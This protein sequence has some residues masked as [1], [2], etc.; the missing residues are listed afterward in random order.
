MKS[1]IT[2]I[3]YYKLKYSCKYFSYKSRN[4]QRVNCLAKHIK[5]K[6]NSGVASP[7]I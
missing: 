5:T 2:E 3:Y 4:T 1:K 7:A 6:R